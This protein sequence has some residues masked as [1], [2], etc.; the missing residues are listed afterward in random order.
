MCINEY[1]VETSFPIAFLLK[2][3]LTHDKWLFHV[4]IARFF[5]LHENF[6][7][8]RMW[9]CEK[10]M[11]S[12]HFHRMSEVSCSARRL[13]FYSFQMFVSIRI[14]KNKKHQLAWWSGSSL[15]WTDENNDENSSY[16]LKKSAWYSTSNFIS[17]CVR[18]IL[19]KLIVDMGEYVHD[20]YINKPKA[21]KK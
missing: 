19:R 6:L 10:M 3:P 21:R 8:L 7:S 2:S 16:W 20:S 11:Q 1:P 4:A 17:F 12:I 14:S 13:I 15:Y 5:L 9:K 18:S